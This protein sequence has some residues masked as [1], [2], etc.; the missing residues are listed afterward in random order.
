MSLQGDEND[1]RLERPRP[2][3]EPIIVGNKNFMNI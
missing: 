2:S 3:L 1:L